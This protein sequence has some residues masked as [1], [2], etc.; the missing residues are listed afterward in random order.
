MK[1]I[2][3]ILGRICMPAIR[4]N[5]VFRFGDLSSKSLG[6]IELAI[7]TPDNIQPIPVLLEV[8]DV[9]IPP[10]ISL[11]FLDDNFLIVD[12]ISNRLWHRIVISNDI[13]EIVDTWSV[14]LI[15]DQHHLYV[16]RHVPMST[17][18]PHISYASS[19][20]SSH[21]YHRSSYIA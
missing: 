2:L 1:R 18:Y 3:D 10:L 7:Q 15:R 8:V 9:D 4:S 17:F 11:D 16:H 12:S 20:D 21:I 5:C 13:F 19:I 6:I 14:P